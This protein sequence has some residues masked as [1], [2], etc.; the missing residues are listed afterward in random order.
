M[1]RMPFGKCQRQGRAGF[2]SG[3]VRAAFQPCGFRTG[4][5]HRGQPL[6]C[7]RTGRQLGRPVQRHPGRGRFAAP[8]AQPAQRNQRHDGRDGR[9]AALADHLF[10]GRAGIVPTT[11]EQPHIRQP[12]QLVQP[13]RIQVALTA[14]SDAT[15]KQRV[16]SRQPQHLRAA[17]AVVREHQAQQLVVAHRFG[18]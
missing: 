8:G 17:R 1:P 5:M 16:G 14:E 2:A 18:H 13:L 6:Q 15:L 4:G 9:R 10:G 11:L 12:R 3:I 7:R